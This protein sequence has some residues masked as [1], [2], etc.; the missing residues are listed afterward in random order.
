MNIVV[1]GSSGFIASNLVTNLSLRHNVIGL[2]KL[3]GD[4]TKIQIDCKS[5][6]LKDTLNWK[7]I[8]LVIDCA[9]RTD[10]DGKNINDYDD[11]YII[12]DRLI[13]ICNNHNIKLI[14]FS[15]MLVNELPLNSVI[16]FN[17]YNPST[18]YG[19]SKVLYER[20]LKSKSKSY[21][22][23]RP[24]SIW[25]PGFK[26]PYRNFFQYVIDGKF[27]VSD[28]N[29]L[30]TYCYIENLIEQ[31]LVLIKDYDKKNYSHQY[32]I[33]GNYNIYDWAKLIRLKSSKNSTNIFLVPKLFFYFICF[34]GDYLKIFIKKFPLNTFRYKN[35]NTSN[36]IDIKYSVFNQQEN[37]YTIEEGVEKTLNHLIT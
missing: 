27:F 18:I 25:G 17:F 32:F 34:L 14:A 1:T 7:E 35:L 3:K 11:N 15:S 13:E 5:K 16:D 6:N 26:E 36:I 22:I 20:K 33:D 8:D 2:D 29:I 24:T 30:K 12:I 9:A 23:V 37:I 28:K 4:N 19:E 21:I 31:I 10:L